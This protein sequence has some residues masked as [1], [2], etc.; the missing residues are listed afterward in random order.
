MSP[1]SIA[2]SSLLAVSGPRGAASRSTHISS[3]N[4]KWSGIILKDLYL[5]NVIYLSLGLKVI[6]V[7][8]NR[9]S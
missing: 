6:Y 1:L 2:S 3:F 7:R 8:N 9:L 4:G 5:Y